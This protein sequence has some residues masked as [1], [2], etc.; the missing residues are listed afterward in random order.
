LIDPAAPGK[1][2]DALWAELPAIQKSG[3]ALGKF[4]GMPFSISRVDDDCVLVDSVSV[5]TFEISRIT[6]AWIY[7]N[8]TKHRYQELSPGN[9]QLILHAVSLIAH[10]VQTWARQED[11]ER[12]VALARSSSRC[13]G[14]F[15]V[16]CY[17]E[18]GRHIGPRPSGEPI[19]LEEVFPS[20]PPSVILSLK[21]D[22]SLLFSDSSLSQGYLASRYPGY[23]AEIYG[24]VVAKNQ[25]NNR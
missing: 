8:W 4:H 23:S 13:D 18:R 14:A 2:F 10:I 19:S 16:V 3:A 20:E 7:S 15:W 11:R 24:S 1:T 12:L 6:L 17:N 9:S 25:M 21:T 5:G 22:A